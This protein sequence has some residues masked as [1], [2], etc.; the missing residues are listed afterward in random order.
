MLT[1]VAAGQPAEQSEQQLREK[2]II[3]GYPS[4]EFEGRRAVSRNELVELVKALTNDLDDAHHRLAGQTEFRNL[5]RL[6]RT[7][8]EELLELESR[9][10]D[11]G[12]SL[13]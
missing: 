1:V 2:G 5:G 8:R 13:D 9:V 12:E 3:Q 7:F 6:L 11:L 4:G 10:D